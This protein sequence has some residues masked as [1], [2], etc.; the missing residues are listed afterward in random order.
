MCNLGP[1]R[2]VNE[3]S[4]A[5]SKRFWFDVVLLLAS[6]KQPQAACELWPVADVPP[7]PTALTPLQ[8]PF[9]A[10]LFIDD[11]EGVEPKGHAAT[12]TSKPKEFA[13]TVPPLYQ[14]SVA[15][16]VPHCAAGV[17]P[18]QSDEVPLDL[19]KYVRAGVL[20]PSHSLAHAIAPRRFDNSVDAGVTVGPAGLSPNFVGWMTAVASRGSVVILR[21]VGRPTM[22]VSVRSTDGDGAVD[23]AAGDE[24]LRKAKERAAATAE[25]AAAA[26]AAATPA[27]APAGP[28]ASAASKSAPAAAAAGP[29]SAPA[30]AA[31]AAGGSGATGDSGASNYA[32]DMYGAASSP[33]YGDDEGDTGYGYGYSGYGSGASAYA[34]VLEGDGGYPGDDDLDMTSADPGAAASYIAEG[35]ATDIDMGGDGGD[36]DGGGDADGAY[37]DAAYADAGYADGAYADAGGTAYGE[38]D[39]ENEDGSGGWTY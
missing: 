6:L 21:S 24:W 39:G 9:I 27:P 16:A 14:R 10:R 2:H 29:T 26:A 23:Y 33:G 1:R 35:S 4:P 17:I 37:A 11:A 25:V 38:D 13:T 3:L 30:P 5:A 31:G 34:S 19:A 18:Q 15:E 8:L 22:T 28:A 20:S 32:D 12:A 36:D 7:V